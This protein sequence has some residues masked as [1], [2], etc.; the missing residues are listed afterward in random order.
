MIRIAA[1]TADS[2]I[3]F[4]NRLE[5]TED[6]TYVWFWVDMSEPTEAEAQLLNTFFHFHPL[7][8][9][10][11]LHLLQ[12]P[13]LDH[14][15]GFHFFVLHAIDPGLLSVE[16]VDLFLHSRY[17]VTY[18]SL[19]SRA[20]E[21]A[22]EKLT[23]HPESFAKGPVY[24]TYVVMDKLVDHFFPAVYEL[25]DLIADIDAADRRGRSK[26]LMDDVFDIRSRLL[27]LRRT[28]VPMRELLYRIVNSERIAGVRD[29]YA[30]Y[31]DIHDHLLKLS[32]MIDSNRELT[33]D[34]RDSYLSYN[35]DRMNTIMK[36]LTVIT[37]IFMPLTF[38]AGVY[39]MNFANMPELE[40][41]WGYFTVLAVM[42][43]IGSGMFAW[44][45][46]KG[47]FD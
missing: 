24:G 9:E 37:T 43:A 27:K 45:K 32:E 17:M 25:E 44:F 2:E 47:W 46:R 13:K 23:R 40:W 22:W 41:H 29:Y 18:H 34:I 38:I 30:F 8:I 7:A 20:V 5:E 14:Y 4:L 6:Q 16:E 3:R 19:A 1:L 28:I 35:S 36:T 31:T 12:R 21:E 11:C 42:I 26:Q 39:G 15:E 10:D 33:A